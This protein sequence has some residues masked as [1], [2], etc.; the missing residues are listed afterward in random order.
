MSGRDPLAQVVRWLCD[1]WEVLWME[2]KMRFRPSARFATKIVSVPLFSGMIRSR[3][4]PLLFAP[5]VP[6][7]SRQSEADALTSPLQTASLTVT[8][9]SGPRTGLFN[10]RAGGAAG[11]GGNGTNV[12]MLDVL[13]GE[14]REQAISYVSSQR[15]F[16]SSFVLG[17]AD[18]SIVPDV[19]VGMQIELV[20]ESRL[21]TSFFCIL[22]SDRTLGS[23]ARCPRIISEFDSLTG[24]VSVHPAWKLAASKSIN[25]VAFR[26]RP[27]LQAGDTVVIRADAEKLRLVVLLD[28]LVFL[29][30]KKT[31]PRQEFVVECGRGSSS[32]S[33]GQGEVT[34]RSLPQLYLDEGYG[35]LKVQ[36]LVDVNETA[37]K[38]VPAQL[39]PSCEQVCSSNL[40]LAAFRADG[41]LGSLVSAVDPAAAPSNGF[42]SCQLRAVSPLVLNFTLPEVRT[43]T[44]KRTRT[45]TRRTRTRTGG[46]EEEESVNREKAVHILRTFT[47]PLT[48][49][50][51]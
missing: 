38:Q 45:R 42:C 47:L 11:M 8:S 28:S 12:N 31:D 23:N 14:V 15:N 33:S 13:R 20:D 49:T 5:N 10:L 27:I 19:Y 18:R 50:G 1:R 44:R 34:A 40:S 22:S 48:V 24:R 7:C 51:T 32:S 6:V 37:V 21:D 29:Q 9:S 3:A 2:P 35:G 39:L 26:I 16:T 4:P 43:R 41:H 36:C 30:K 25:Q 46:E 17:A